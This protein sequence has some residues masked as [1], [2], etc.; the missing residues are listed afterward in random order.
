MSVDLA[1]F[2]DYLRDRGRA[3]HD[4]N[5]APDI[6]RPEIDRKLAQRLLAL[7]RIATGSLPDRYLSARGLWQ[8]EYPPD[9]RQTKDGNMVSIVRE[10][11][12]MVC[13]YQLMVLSE[14]PLGYPR[15]DA[16]RMMKNPDGYK[17]PRSGAVRLGHIEDEMGVGEGVETA[18]SAKSRF[19]VNTWAL[20][21][22]SR[23]GVW[24]P[25]AGIGTLHIFKDRTRDDILAKA[26]ETGKISPVERDAVALAKRASCMG[27]KVY[28]HEPERRMG[29]DISD[30]NDLLVDDYKIG[31]TME[32][33][34]S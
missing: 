17:M 7:P 33:P 23:L 14:G 3:E 5:F 10:A 26:A 9:L 6:C 32:G 2:Q 19:D 24:T 12:G 16:V 8:P 13:S 29:R 20:L 18:M 4:I 34:R 31:K 15:K 22:T 11:S 1:S 28:V 25:P 30:Q 27:I 21:G